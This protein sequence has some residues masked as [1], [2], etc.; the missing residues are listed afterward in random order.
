MAVASVAGRMLGELAAA[1]WGVELDRQVARDLRMLFLKGVNPWDF[2]LGEGPEE[3][4]RNLA[5]A[6]GRVVL[7][8][9][10]LCPADS[11]CELVVDGGMD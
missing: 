1:L 11:R 9:T 6:L 7:D 4:W 8:G 3:A 2:G 5:H 10:G